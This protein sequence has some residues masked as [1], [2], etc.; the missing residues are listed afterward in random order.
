M[1]VLKNKR[2]PSNCLCNW[3]LT[4]HFSC[5]IKD[6]LGKHYLETWGIIS[7]LRKCFL[8]YIGGLHVPVYAFG[9]C[10]DFLYNWTNYLYFC[11][12]LLGAVFCLRIAPVLAFL[13]LMSIYDSMQSTCVKSISLHVSLVPMTIGLRC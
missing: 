2:K 11:W 6:L 10:Q 1:F 4:W 9:F 3:P 5:N 12:L 8:Y 13:S 7:I